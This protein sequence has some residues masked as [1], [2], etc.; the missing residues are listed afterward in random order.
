[1][2]RWLLALLILLAFEALLLRRIPRTVEG[3]LY[4]SS[5]RLMVRP[6][7]ASVIAFGNKVDVSATD[8]SG[9]DL[10]FLDFEMVRAILADREM[11]A[12]IAA[13][14]P[15]MSAQDIQNRIVA[16]PSALSFEDL[17]NIHEDSQVAGAEQ[18]VQA[19]QD[20]MTYLYGKPVQTLR[21]VTLSISGDNPE[22]ARALAE[23]TTE[24][25]LAAA[26][27]K[28][29][30]NYTRRREQLEA[31]LEDSLKQ[32]RKAEEKLAKKSSNILEKGSPDSSNEVLLRYLESRKASLLA[33]RF[34]LEAHL[35]RLEDA[36]QVDLSPSLKAGQAQ[37]HKAELEVAML[38]RTYLPDD[39][40]VSLSKER[41]ESFG[42]L[43][44]QMQVEL[45]QQVSSGDTMSL[46]GV[47][48]ELSQVQ[49][50][51][52][53]IEAGRPDLKQLREAKMD[54]FR[55]DQWETNK[56]DLITRTLQA[57]VQERQ[58]QAQGTMIVLEHPQPGTLARVTRVANWVTPVA[59]FPVGCFLAVWG[60]VLVDRLRR[61]RYGADRVAAGL[62]LELLAALP[63]HPRGRANQ[64]RRW[65]RD[66][67]RSS[68]P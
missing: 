47:N 46:D 16:Y 19:Y 43:V 37:L 22:Q 18:A 5:A 28:A 61:A 64:W 34:S 39:P 17:S 48:L 9:I 6:S 7:S 36:G 65:K 49:A 24:E 26:R 33:Q 29:A 35:S 2:R 4:V 44:G 63:P 67:S 62:G 38:E 56:L 58:A 32:A 1:M 31:M 23:A 12:R 50:E 11:L 60:A 53:A 27:A 59:M 41:R 14:V 8:S 3:D 15:E 51:I 68:S 40:L 45:H 66:L 57:R 21:L 54:Q 10:W 52:D 42:Q 55:F 25:F 13:R 20:E 30:E